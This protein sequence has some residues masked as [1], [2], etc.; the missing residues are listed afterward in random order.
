VGLVDTT[1]TLADAVAMAGQAA[2]LGEGP[3]RT[4]VLPR[5]KTF[6]QRFSQQFA[7]QARRAWRS[8]TM[9]TVDETLWQKRRLL[10]RMIGSEGAIQTRLPVTP[11]IE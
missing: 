1:G 4:R 3:Y 5:P 9:G 2:G 10:N 11:T 6:L 7:A 8:A